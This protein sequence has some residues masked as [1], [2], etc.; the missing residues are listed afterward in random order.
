[1][2]VL[3]GQSYDFEAIGRAIDGLL[4]ATPGLAAAWAAEWDDDIADGPERNL[5]IESGTIASYMIQLAATSERS[6][7]L[8]SIVA[9]LE[10]LFD[11][12]IA[13]LDNWMQIGLIESLQHIASNEHLRGTQAVSAGAVRARLGP[14]AQ[15]SWDALTRQWGNSV[16]NL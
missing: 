11:L 9:A 4:S 15:A 13:G 6:P 3:G 2:R 5:W 10:L 16:D 7:E 14:K 1:M 8:N 12:E